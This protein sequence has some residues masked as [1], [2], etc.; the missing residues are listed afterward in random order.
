MHCFIETNTGTQPASNKVRDNSKELI[1]QEQHG[2]FERRITQQMKV[3]YNQHSNG[4]VSHG[5]C[6]I[7]AGHNGVMTQFSCHG[8]YRSLASISR[9]SAMRHT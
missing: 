9:M 7:A 8:S 5:K 3:E 4:A 1:K 6:P 2:D